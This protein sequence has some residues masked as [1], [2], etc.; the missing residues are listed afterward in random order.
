LRSDISITMSTYASL[1]LGIGAAASAAIV[2]RYLA[3]V[4]AAYTTTLRKR[5]KKELLKAE[6]ELGYRLILKDFNR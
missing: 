2:T 6:K 3:D 1:L 4:A 5:A